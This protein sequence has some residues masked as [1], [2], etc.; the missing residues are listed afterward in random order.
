MLFCLLFPAC[1][2]AKADSRIRFGGVPVEL[3]VSQVSER[4]VRFSCRH[5]MS[6]DVARGEPSSA[7]FVPFPATEKLRVRE[8]AGTKELRVGQ[9]RVTIKPQPLTISVRRRGRNTG[10][11]TCF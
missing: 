9:L 4:T 10:A 8:L 7:F 3:T 11:G 5:W 1:P 6:R 2:V